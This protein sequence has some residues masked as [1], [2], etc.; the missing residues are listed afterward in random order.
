MAPHP[1]SPFTREESITIGG[2]TYTRHVDDTASTM[3]GPLYT[4]GNCA[5]TDQEE[6]IHK[7]KKQRES[8]WK[9]VNQRKRGLR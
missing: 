5:V 4:Y 9:M 3:L 7:D 8:Y 6:D 1:S 2:V